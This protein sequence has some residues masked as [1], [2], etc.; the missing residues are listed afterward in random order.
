MSL[1]W[2]MFFLASMGLVSD[3]DHCNNTEYDTVKYK[4]FT[5]LGL[6]KN[7]YQITR[8][9]PL[10]FLPHLAIIYVDLYVTS[11]IEVN[12]KDQSLTTQVKIITAWPN[13]NMQWNK[14]LFCEME[15]CVAPKNLFWTPDI[16][17]IESIKT[18]FGTKE[19]PYVRLIH[20]GIIASSDILALTTACRMDLYRFPF[21]SHTCNI[22]LQSTAHSSQEITIDKFSGATWVTIESK[23]TFH[24]Q[25]EWE[26]ISINVTKSVAKII[27]LIEMDQLI[28]QVNC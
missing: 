7:D 5:H 19:S 3:A 16:G 8:M 10:I 22:T 17:I 11:I 12:E 1:H 6:D 18:D 26:L 9:W 23:K 14:S 27:G 21:D 15:T 25:G 4:L 28:Y 13:S 2:L 24:T 20:I